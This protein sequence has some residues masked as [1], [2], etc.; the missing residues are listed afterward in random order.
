MRNCFSVCL[1]GIL[2]LGLSAQPILTPGQF[3]FTSF[4]TDTFFLAT[5]GNPAVTTINIG[6]FQG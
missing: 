3:G 5:P 2:S 6:S 1:F 4:T